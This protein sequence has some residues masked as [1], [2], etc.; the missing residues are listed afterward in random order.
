M[1]MRI[2]LTLK[3]KAHQLA[4]FEANLLIMIVSTHKVSGVV[5]CDLSPPG[6]LFILDLKLRVFL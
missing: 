1:K 6:E 4:P 2:K 5:C 3:V